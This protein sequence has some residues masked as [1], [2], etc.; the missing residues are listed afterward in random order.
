MGMEQD[1]TWGRKGQ[2][3]GEQGPCMGF[4]P[5]EPS[6]TNPLAQTG[7]YP[8]FPESKGISGARLGEG[9]REWGGR[10]IR[11]LI[12]THQEHTYPIPVLS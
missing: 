12:M 9:R 6:E 8:S 7:I 2:Q 10:E 5:L 1:K 4:Q 11:F 3:V